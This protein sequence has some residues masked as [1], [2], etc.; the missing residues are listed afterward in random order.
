MDMIKR[1]FGYYWVMYDGDWYI[2]EYE[3]D[4]ND[5]SDI[6]WLCGYPNKFQESELQEIDPKQIP[7]HE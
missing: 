4:H 2:G 7:K 3:L 1:E 6:W 5:N